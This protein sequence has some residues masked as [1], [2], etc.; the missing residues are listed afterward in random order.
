MHFA[1]SVL[2]YPSSAIAVYGRFV[3]VAVSG[4]NY[5]YVYGRI[6]TKAYRAL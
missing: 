2:S 1:A 4:N 5:V 6:V 3:I